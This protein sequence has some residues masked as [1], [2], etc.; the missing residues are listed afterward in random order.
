VAGRRRELGIR[1]A[2][3]A[4]GSKI[5]GLVAWYALGIVGLGTATGLAA[6]YGLARP[7]ESRLFGVAPTDPASYAGSALLFAAVAAAACWSPTR[8]ALRVDPVVTLRSE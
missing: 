2:L 5:A 4:D 1:L 3:G 8:S 6:A 7:V